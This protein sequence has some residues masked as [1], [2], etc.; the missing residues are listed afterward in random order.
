MPD[1]NR[2]LATEKR[3]EIVWTTYYSPFLR[4]LGKS[5]QKSFT[6]SLLAVAIWY[7]VHYHRWQRILLCHFLAF[8]RGI[9][10]KSCVQV[11]GF[12]LSGWRGSWLRAVFVA[13]KTSCFT[14]EGMAVSGY[15]AWCSEVKQVVLLEKGWWQ[16]VTEQNPLSLH[17]QS[18]VTNTC[19]GKWQSKQK[20]EKIFWSREE[21][22]PIFD[23]ALKFLL[24]GVFY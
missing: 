17:L 5:F 24:Y 12:A 3:K 10:C 1:P 19:R 23:I 16:R 20:G 22:A 7:I 14:A 9:S 8:L 6:L 21:E 18:W 15:E 11:W 13:S 2:R 4:Q